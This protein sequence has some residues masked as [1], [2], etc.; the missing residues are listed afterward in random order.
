MVQAGNELGGR[1]RVLVVEDDPVLRRAMVR[2]L[3]RRGFW[4]IEAGDGAQALEQLDDHEVLNELGCD[5]LQ[6]YLF[7]RPQLLELTGVG[8]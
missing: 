7:G 4:L 2:M 5:L 3:A 6:G 1:G 8:E